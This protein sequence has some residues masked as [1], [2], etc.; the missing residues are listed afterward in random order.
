MYPFGVSS[1]SVVSLLYKGQDQ[2]LVREGFRFTTIV[3]AN[4][5][6]LL[7]VGPPF[8]PELH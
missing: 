1:Q 6:H 5:S 7:V 4:C 3:I 8:G 2:S